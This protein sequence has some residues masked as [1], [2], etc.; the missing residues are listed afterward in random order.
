MIIGQEMADIRHGVGRRTVAI[1]G[2]VRCGYFFRSRLANTF[3]LRTLYPAPSQMCKST[4]KAVPE[5]VKL[6]NGPVQH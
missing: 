2:V 5:A 1:F 4:K 6:I 3:S